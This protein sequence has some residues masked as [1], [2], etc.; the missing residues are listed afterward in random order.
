MRI[1]ALGRIVNSRSS[2]QD[3]R[4]RRRLQWDVWTYLQLQCPTHD[5]YHGESLPFA[6]LPLSFQIALIAVH[7]G[8]SFSLTSQGKGAVGWGIKTAYFFACAATIGVVLVYFFVP[9][10][11]NRTFAELNELYEAKVPARK[12]RQ[13]KTQ[14]QIVAEAG[15]V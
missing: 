11:K 8:D 9:E 3:C 12:F 2:C 4:F 15:R 13:T 7:G 14:V 5:P 1:L 10:H 6:V